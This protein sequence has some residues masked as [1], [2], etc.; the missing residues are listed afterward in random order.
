MNGGRLHNNKRVYPI[1][2]FY[3]YMSTKKQ[4]HT[5]DHSGK[6]PEVPI[7]TCCPST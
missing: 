2:M 1:S 6:L 5:F 3:M 4:F 7:R